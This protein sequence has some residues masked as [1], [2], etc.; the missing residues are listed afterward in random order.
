MNDPIFYT[1]TLID[2]GVLFTLGV[3]WSA[4]VWTISEALILRAALKRPYSRRT[5]QIVTWGP[6]VFATV[7]TVILMPWAVEGV[8]GAI[9]GFKVETPLGP[10]EA[11]Y[12]IPYFFLTVVLG[13]V[14]GVAAKLANDHAYELVR[15]TLGR[16]AKALAGKS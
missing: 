1:L 7:G 3:I 12:S 8:G 2:L 16:I 11:P 10:F 6:I 5:R 14:S 9:P 4:T 15:A 13:L